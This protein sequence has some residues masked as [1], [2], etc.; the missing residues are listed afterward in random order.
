MAQ[1]YHI[2]HSH[3][4][5]MHSFSLLFSCEFVYSTILGLLIQTETDLKYFILFFPTSLELPWRRGRWPLE[6]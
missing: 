2:L 1:I 3:L 5:I 6:V 4:E